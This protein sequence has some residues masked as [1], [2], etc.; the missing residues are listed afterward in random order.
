MDSTITYQCIQII[1]QNKR[2]NKERGRARE[3]IYLHMD[4]DMN[5]KILL[6]C[7]YIVKALSRTNDLFDVRRNSLEFIAVD[8]ID[9][10]G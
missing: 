4:Y 6:S 5:I 8:S 10:K 9:T 2:A 7:R 3:S 1:A